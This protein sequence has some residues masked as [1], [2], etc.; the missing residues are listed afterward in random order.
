MKISWRLSAVIAMACCALALGACELVADT[1]SPYR[2]TSTKGQPGEGVPV[3]TESHPAARNYLPAVLYRECS[4]AEYPLFEVLNQQPI[5]KTRPFLEALG[6]IQDYNLTRMSGNNLLWEDGVQKAINQ[7][8]RLGWR[9]EFQTSQGPRTGWVFE[10]EHSMGGA[11]LPGGGTV[12][13]LAALTDGAYH[14]ITFHKYRTYQMAKI[15]PAAEQLADML[16]VDFTNPILHHVDRLTF[17]A[18]D[19]W[20]HPLPEPGTGS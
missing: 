10:G 14:I 19:L 16:Y 7:R 5:E 4:V 2:V 15:A 11:S 6:V 20:M 17:S 12:G 1:T 18:E 13:V 9:Q 8:Y 3:P